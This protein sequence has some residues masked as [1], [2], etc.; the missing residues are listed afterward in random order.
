MTIEELKVGTRDPGGLAIG[1]DAAGLLERLRVVPDGLPVKFLR[2]NS[3]NE[4]LAYFA[5]SV[6]LLTDKKTGAPG[7]LQVWLMPEINGQDND[8][9]D[10]A[11]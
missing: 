1:F 6:R 8:R 10:D 2:V 5:A 9:E 4:T 7:E 3:D 11:G